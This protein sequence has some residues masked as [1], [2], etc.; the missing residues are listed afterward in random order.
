MVSTGSRG[1]GAS[2]LSSKSWSSPT[3]KLL[4]R[5][6]LRGARE[7]RTQTGMDKEALSWSEALLESLVDDQVIEEAIREELGL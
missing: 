5:G 3:W 2:V 4:P 7:V 1:P 6:E